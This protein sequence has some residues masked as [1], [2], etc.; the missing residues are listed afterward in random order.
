MIL[1][2]LFLFDP[3]ELAELLGIKPADLAAL[4]LRGRASLQYHGVRYE[5][6]FGVLPPEASPPE[7]PAAH[8][9]P[10]AA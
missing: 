5:Q 8:A 2:Y 6:L 7:T 3:V 10:D 9:V 1:F 4:L